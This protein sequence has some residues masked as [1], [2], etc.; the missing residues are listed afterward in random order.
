MT[1]TGTA[2][3]WPGPSLSRPT[4]SWAWPAWLSAPRSCAQGAVGQGSGSMGAIRLAIP[5]RGR[6]R[7]QVVNMSSVGPLSGGRHPQRREVR[8]GKGVLC[9]GGGRQRRPRTRELPSQIPR[10]TGG[11]RPHP[12]RRE[13]DLLFELGRRRGQSP[14]PAATSGSTR[15]G[16]ASPTASAEHGGPGQHQPDPSYLSS[17]APRWP[18]RTWPAWPR[19]S[20][21]RA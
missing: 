11:G 14:P 21:A 18:P 4:T 7:R 8:D 9:G 3:T 17:W 2:P 20:P 16:T 13:H 19:C 6:P 1:I 12:V 15:T 5:L 10:G